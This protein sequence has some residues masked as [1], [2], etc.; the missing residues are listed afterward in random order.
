MDLQEVIAKRKSV[1][2]YTG[3]SLTEDQISK[4]LTAANLSPVGMAKYDTLHITVVTDK[5]MLDAIDKA[6]ADFFG[7]P[8]MHPLYGVPALFVV[9]SNVEG[10]VSS[11][12]CAIAVHTMSLAAVDAGLGQVLIYGATA[13]LAQNKVL[14]A[15][16]A[17]PDGFTPVASLAVGKTTDTYEPR[18]AED[19]IQVNY[20]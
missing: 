14:I 18:Q 11:A 20:I 15:K 8:D 2:S 5:A 16:L 3:E 9:S 10:N 19:K 1:R 13:A 12:N 4:I 17:I 7:N 6:G